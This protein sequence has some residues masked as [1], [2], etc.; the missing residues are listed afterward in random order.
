MQE[1]TEEMPQL[2][3]DS[4]IETLFNIIDSYTQAVADMKRVRYEARSFLSSG[5]SKNGIKP[6]NPIEYDYKAG[7]QAVSEMKNVAD[8]NGDEFPLGESGLYDR[9]AAYY[10]SIG[11]RAY[12]DIL[13]YVELGKRGVKDSFAHGVGIKKTAAFK[14]VPD[15]IQQG[16]LVDYQTNWKGRGYDT[17]VIAAPISIEG[18]SYYAAV[19]VRRTKDNQ[20]FYL[21]EIDIEKRQAVLTKATTAKE[22]VSST[23]ELGGSPFINSIFEKIRNVNSLDEN[24]NKE[25]TSNL[26][27]RSVDDGL[28]EIKSLMA[29]TLIVSLESKGTELVILL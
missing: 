8:L 1:I 15:I 22:N 12:N 24:Y 14:A 2:A 6:F 26:T 16:N 9:I 17:A 4:D 27:P 7:I 3:K 29:K 18:E 10:D 11:G 28:S 13:G 5:L 23:K 20:R 19:I 21:H 25:L